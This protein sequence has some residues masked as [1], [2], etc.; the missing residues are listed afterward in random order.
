MS[1]RIKE[2]NFANTMQM[3]HDGIGNYVDING[4][5]HYYLTTALVDGVTSTTSGGSTAPA[6]STAQTSHATG[7]GVR[8][9][10]GASLWAASGGVTPVADSPYKIY[11]AKF[12][13]A[14]TAAPTAEVR[15]N[16]LSGAIVLGRTSAGLYTLTL[17]SAFPTGKVTP[18]VSLSENAT[19]VI[20]KLGRTS[21]NV[22][23]L[24]TFDIAGAAADLVGD[25]FV[26]IHVIP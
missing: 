2:P 9:V 13:Q 15:V 7:K 3:K 18:L 6:G 25:A 19:A 16:G 10:A 22:L 17:A 21:D 1:R 14:G 4:Q 20:A 23:T 12:N 26:M 11:E 24:R 8:F 5:R